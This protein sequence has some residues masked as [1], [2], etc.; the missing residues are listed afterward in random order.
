MKV[1][2]YGAFITAYRKANRITQR[3]LSNHLGFTSVHISRIEAGDQLI[4]L[5]KLK[6]IVMAINELAIPVDKN[7]KAKASRVLKSES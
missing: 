2:E 5:D 1:E 7:L 4:K 3:D 6:R